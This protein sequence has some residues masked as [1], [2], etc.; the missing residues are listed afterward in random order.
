MLF[1]NIFHPR[2]SYDS[3]ILST[4]V[5]IIAV[6]TILAETCSG[7]NKYIQAPKQNPAL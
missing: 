4:S 6:N 7:F 1:W 3:N 5:F 2:E